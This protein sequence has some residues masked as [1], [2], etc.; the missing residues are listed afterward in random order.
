MQSTAL[1]LSLYYGVLFLA[2]GVYTPF[3]PLWLASRGLDAIEI[4]IVSAIGIAVKAV[5]SPLAAHVA[6]RSGERRRLMGWFGIATLLGFGFLGFAH[7][8]WPVLLLTVLYMVFWS[9]ILPLG[10]SLVMMAIRDSGLHYSRLRVWGSITFILAAA[11]TGHLLV[12]GDPDLVFWLLLVALGGLAAV[13]GVLPDERAPRAVGHLPLAAMARDRRFR[14]FLLAA[15]LIQSSHA[16]YY[17]FATLHWQKA[18]YS[19]DLIGALWAEGVI[20]EILLFTWGIPLVR[21]LGPERLLISA[22]LAAV[23]RWLVLGTTT[24]LAPL[25]V[26]QALHAFTF[27]AAHL[28]AIHYMARHVPP[29]LSATAQSL[30]AALVMGLGLGIAVLGGGPLFA[31]WEGGAFAAMAVLGGGGAIAAFLLSRKTG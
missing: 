27:G 29:Q 6:D 14:L 18:G 11:G 9:P 30:Y 22:G 4:G 1:R 17:T 19:A 13:I 12:D 21:R 8:F 20:A 24:A 25:L 7:G 15:A 5:S 23:L 10:E 3:W 2:I 26:S 28:G 16:V 31:A